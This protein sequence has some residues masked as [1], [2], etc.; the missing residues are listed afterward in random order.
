MGFSSLYESG[1][2]AKYRGHY[3]NL[4]MIARADGKIDASE[5][6]LLNK[7][8]SRIGI[9]SEMMQEI[10]D[11]PEKYPTVAP[12]SREERYER[13]IQLLEMVFIDGS[14]DP[15]ELAQVRKYGIG[16][17]F[18]EESMNNKFDIIVEKIEAGKDRSEILEEVM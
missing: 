16:L 13:F 3:R 4:L 14:A 12:N 9:N 15:S 8:A 18:T 7:I 6:A 10:S 1:E 2:K 5:E 17:G 11:H